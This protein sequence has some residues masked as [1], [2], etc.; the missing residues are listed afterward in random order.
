VSE[1]EVREL[2]DM[3]DLM[4][5]HALIDSIWRPAPGAAPLS[6]ETMRAL[7]HAGNYVA[8]AYLDG[9]MAGT[10]IA[11]LADPPGQSLHSHIT[12]ALSGSGA[13]LALKLHQRQWALDRGLSRI[14]WTFDPLV[15]RN[16][17]F[18]LAKLAALPREYLTSFYG[19][20]S[21]AINA[22]DESDRILAV[23]P[24]ADPAVTAAASGT[25]RRVTVP[26]DA[27]PA[28]IVRN[29]APHLPA[30]TGR[31]VLVEIPADIER[32][33]QDDPGKAKAWRLAVREVLGGLMAEGAEVTGFH[34]KRCYVVDRGRDA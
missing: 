21:D 18:N 29:E 7:A 6:A 14:T 16:A 15:R 9:R 26:A 1:I 34:G 10:S 28:L 20:M 4:A 5:A 23:W 22:D 13:G 30:V 12:G 3:A 32:L 31:T 33:R 27:A 11:F 19:T 8:A 25:P 17:H 2:H 24:L